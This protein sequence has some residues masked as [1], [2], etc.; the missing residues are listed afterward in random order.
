LKECPGLVMMIQDAD[1]CKLTTLP[2]SQNPQ[3]SK[4]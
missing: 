1:F 2:A 4:D 3:Q